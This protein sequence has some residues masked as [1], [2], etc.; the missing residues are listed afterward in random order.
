MPW[1]LLFV[2]SGTRSTPSSEIEHSP[3]RAISTPGCETP[4]RVVGILPQFLERLDELLSANRSPEGA[5][6]AVGFLLHDLL[7]QIDARH[8]AALTR[9]LNQRRLVSP[10]GPP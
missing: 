10:V 1:T 4:D 5:P 6:F 7:N 2:G 3:R 9:R 8:G